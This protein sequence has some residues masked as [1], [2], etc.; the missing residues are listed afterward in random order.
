MARY[1]LCPRLKIKARLTNVRGHLNLKEEVLI[2]AHATAITPAEFAWVSWRVLSDE[3][4]SVLLILG[5]EFQ[6]SSL[7]L[8]QMG[9]FMKALFFPIVTVALFLTSCST[10]DLPLSSAQ[11]YQVPRYQL[12]DNLLDSRFGPSPG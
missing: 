10:V 4:R 12:D 9:C 8:G 5:H 11:R 6:E 1:R 2:R 7:C 3:A